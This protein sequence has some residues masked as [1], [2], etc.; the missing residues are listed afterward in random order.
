[1][2][3]R[4]GERARRGASR[5]LVCGFATITA[6]QDTG[7]MLRDAVSC[8]LHKQPVICVNNGKSTE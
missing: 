7:D 8:G 4:M 2:Q 1:M 6:F 3:T 5:R